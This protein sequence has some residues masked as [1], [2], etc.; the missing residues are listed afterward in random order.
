MAEDY[1]GMTNKELL[2]MIMHRIESLDERE[3][4][5]QRKMERL[6]GREEAEEK[7]E[8]KWSREKAVL[9]G[10]TL[11]AVLFFVE[12]VLRLMGI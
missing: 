3:R 11:T 9:I 4:I 10:W 1:K 7:T 5:L 12:I 2:R 8:E 6:L